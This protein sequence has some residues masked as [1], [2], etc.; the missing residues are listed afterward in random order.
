MRANAFKNNLYRN[1]QQFVAAFGQTLKYPEY[2]KE[3]L[4]SQFEDST[5]SYFGSSQLRRER[6]PREEEFDVFFFAEK[7]THIKFSYFF[8]YLG[9]HSIKDG[10][11]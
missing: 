2:P 9:E 1:I 4:K 6:G 11:N 10:F 5:F 8:G 3:I 7:M